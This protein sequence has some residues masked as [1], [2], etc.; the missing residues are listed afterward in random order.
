MSFDSV[1]PSNYLILCCPFLLRSIFPST[2]VSSSELALCIWWPKYWLFTLI[3]SPS[4]E[5]ST[6][7]S[8]RIDWFDLAVQG[9]LPNPGIEPRSPTLQVDS[10]PS[11]PLANFLW[12][13]DDLSHSQLQVLFLLT[14]YSF[15]IFNY[16]ECNQFDFSIDHLVMYMCKVVSWFVEKG[17]MLWL[18]HSRGR[19]QLAFALLHFVFQDQTWLLLQVYLDFIL[20]H[21]NLQ[22]WIEH[23]FSVF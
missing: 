15:S 20:L 16:K 8:F 2:K 1:M 6:L 4:N 18:V 21:S 3:I 19:I 13:A 10:L 7:I 5:Y 22:W 14:V 12:E 11:E 23:L 9:D 17:C